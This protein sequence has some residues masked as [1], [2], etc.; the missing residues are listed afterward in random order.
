MANENNLKAPS[1]NEARERGRKGGIASG[2]A[3]REKQRWSEFFSQY[4]EQDFINADGK[5]LL[6]PD[7][8][9]P[10]TRQENL[11]RNLLIA[12]SNATVNAE[13]VKSP[14]NIK[15]L[16]ESMAIIRDTMGE[17]PTDKVITDSFTDAEQEDFK[18]IVMDIKDEDNR[19]A[20]T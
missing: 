2:K 9:K 17:K 3:R 1:T 19:S 8:G 16:L 5:V 6:N 7:T 15:T 11:V 10:L 13:F 20:K 4:L 14:K 18:R 12:L